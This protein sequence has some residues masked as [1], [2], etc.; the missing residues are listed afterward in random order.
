M[1]RNSII[2]DP[3]SPPGHWEERIKSQDELGVQELVGMCTSEPLVQN[4]EATVTPH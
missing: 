3:L 4:R 1:A 2:L